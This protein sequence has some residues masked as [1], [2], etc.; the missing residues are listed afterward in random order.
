MEKSA[1][2]INVKTKEMEWIDIATGELPVSGT[3]VIVKTENKV[4][5]NKQHAYTGKHTI[6]CNFHLNEKDEP[7]WGCNNQIVTHFLKEY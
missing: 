5:I 3:K 1:T 6:Q 7:I 4:M 2:V